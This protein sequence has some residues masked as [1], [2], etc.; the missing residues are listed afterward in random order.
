MRI[1]ATAIPG[2]LL[3]E[4][5]VFRD[6]R[7]E[8]LETWNRRELAA[9][10]I[11]AEFVQDNLSRSRQ[12]TLRGIHYQM[13]QAQG[14]LVRVL[15]GEAYDVAVDLRRSSPTFGQ[16]VAMRLSAEN[17]HALWIPPGFAHGLMALADDTRVLYKATD[18]YAPE[19]ERTLAWNDPALGI[20][21]PLPTAVQPLMSDKDRQGAL[22]ATAETYP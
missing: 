16:H 11:D 8:F 15:A 4:P 19:A 12:W 13:R 6:S 3:V 7:G 18:F 5:R 22:L 14:K 2:V 1:Q 21:W 20:E 17:L 10:G 9:A